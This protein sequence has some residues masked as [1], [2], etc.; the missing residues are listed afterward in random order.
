[1]KRLCS[2]LVVSLVLLIGIGNAQAQSDK[3]QTGQAPQVS[4]FT[5]SW[6]LDKPKS[7]AK[8]FPPKLKGYRMV[9]AE[10][11]GFLNVKS[12]VDG[13]VEVQAGRVRGDSS[14]AV[15]GSSARSTSTTQAASATS[16]SGQIE[17]ASFGGTLAL[18]FTPNE[19]RYNL[20][21]QETKVELMQGDKANGVARIKAKVDK[22]GKGMQF[23][24]IRKTR[25]PQGE[26]EITTR[27]WWKLADDGKSIRMDRTVETATTRDE[28][29]MFLNKVE[30]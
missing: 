30:Q 20:S 18:Y 7:V 19:A 14:P 2:G 15:A 27:E 25:T 1:M 29:T 4:A 26:I 12:Q 23:T 10:S 21:G 28:V 22:N 6:V 5:G 9:V 17:K 24:T 3:P 16:G 13:G 11:D 8:N